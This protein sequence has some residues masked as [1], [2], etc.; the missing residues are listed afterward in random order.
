MFQ[1][2]VLPD[3]PLPSDLGSARDRPR[4]GCKVR[5]CQAGRR[6]PACLGVR[7]MVSVE[8]EGN[9]SNGVWRGKAGRLAI[10][11]AMYQEGNSQQRHV[12]HG[13]GT[14]GSGR[15]AGRRSGFSVC[16]CFTGEARAVTR[17]KALRR[18]V[19][20]CVFIT[21][22]VYGCFYFLSLLS[23]RLTSHTVPPVVATNAPAGM[24]LFV[25]FVH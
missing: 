5:D 25:P 20:V 15:C 4:A 16:V 19:S 7:A 12:V 23:T 10:Q 14:R 3:N 1:S 6:R 18:R 8:K 13:Q 17:A 11:Y 21:G 22:E 9:V 24:D 2:S